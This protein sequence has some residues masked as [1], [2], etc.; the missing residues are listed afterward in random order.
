MKRC[1]E[2]YH[3]KTSDFQFVAIS[4]DEDR[5]SAETY[6]QKA[7]LPFPVLLD[8]GHEAADAYSVEAIPATFIVDKGG[9][10][11][12]TQTGSDE[13]ME[14]KLAIQ[15]GINLDTVAGRVGGK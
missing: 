9:K 8:L 2:K 7:K 3:K 12:Q 10:V 15:L 5:E 4:I 14:I 11:K 1:F 6:A 13:T